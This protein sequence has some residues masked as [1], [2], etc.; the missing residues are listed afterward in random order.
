MNKLDK[1][2]NT[3]ELNDMLAYLMK[4][5]AGRKFIKEKFEKLKNLFL[6]NQED[7]RFFSGPNKRF[8]G[9]GINI[10]LNSFFQFIRTLKDIPEFEDEYNHYSYW[11]KLYDELKIPEYEKPSI[12]DIFKMKETELRRINVARDGKIIKDVVFSRILL[13]ENK[14]ER[15][16]KA[17]VLQEVA[18]GNPY[19][20]ISCG[21]SSLIIQA[22]EQVVK[23]GLGRR[24]FEIPYH[25][26]I[27]MPY[28]R[29]KYSDESCL[30]VFNYGDIETAEI[31]DERLLEI[32]KELEESGIIWGDASKKNLAVL[33]KDNDLPEF[34]KSKEF[35]LFGFLQDD[36]FP[37]NN[38]I[39]L[40]TGDIV[41]CDLDML[42]TKEDPDC[43]F[44]D[45]DDVIEDYL[46]E[47]IT[48]PKDSEYDIDKSDLR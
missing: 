3:A 17:I 46:M 40:K 4:E 38:H 5:N 15:E 36:R 20:F 14:E 41:V 28:F 19:E 44:G 2:S 11:G 47:R 35:N 43:H 37:T 39:A 33:K 32:Y 29:K 21:T 23:L 7:S 12:D 34:I 25:P 10:Q 24:K 26:R 6:N 13:A 9:E 16:E 18:Q 48:K 42:Y 22:G 31:T 8:F 27:M 30:E 45:L 1:I